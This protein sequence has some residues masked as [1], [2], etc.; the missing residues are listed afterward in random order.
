MEALMTPPNTTRQS[1]THSDS[2]DSQRRILFVCLGNICRSPTAEGILRHLAAQERSDIDFVI[3]SAGIAGYHVGKSPD[4]RAIE[5][6]RQAGV[7]ISDQCARKI[8]L[9][10]FSS[11]DHIYAM[12]Q[13]NIDS[14]MEI[15]PAEF[16]HKIQSLVEVMPGL[17][18]THVSD[19]YHGDE[20]DFEQMN[21]VLLV[22]CNQLLRGHILSRRVSQ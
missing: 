9:D 4:P 2:M 18:L 1:D 6:A 7:D 14:L 15:C 22:L 13:R 16:Q 19:P 5:A 3:D 10:D 12:D 20:V 17:G 8:T 11:F 21:G